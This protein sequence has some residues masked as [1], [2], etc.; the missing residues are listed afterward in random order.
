MAKPRITVKCTI[1]NLPNTIDVDVTE[2]DTGDSKLIRDLPTI[3]NVQILDSE[4][5][6]V[7][8]VIKAK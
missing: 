6:A 1:E 7:I 8:S 3:P 5:V 4:R 2:M